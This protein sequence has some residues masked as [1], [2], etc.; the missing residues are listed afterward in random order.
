MN[1]IHLPQVILAAL[2]AITVREPYPHNTLHTLRENARYGSVPTVRSTDEITNLNISHPFEAGWSNHKRIK[3]LRLPAA[4][5]A[6][7]S[8]TFMME[9][10][11]EE[12]NLIVMQGDG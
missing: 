10:I 9:D 1:G 7:H 2:D 11:V 8:A 3:R 4:S 5:R 12:V 6:V